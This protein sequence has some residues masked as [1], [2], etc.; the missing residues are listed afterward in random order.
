MPARYPTVDFSNDAFSFHASSVLGSVGYGQ[1]LS[2]DQ[3]LVSYEVVLWNISILATMSIDLLGSLAACH[4]TRRSCTHYWHPRT[5][6]L[7]G[8]C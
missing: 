3:S 1:K 6:I 7:R 4:R 2:A 5:R 8:L